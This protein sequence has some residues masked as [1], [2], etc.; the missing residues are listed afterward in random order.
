MASTLAG[1]GF[2]IKQLATWGATRFSGIYIRTAKSIVNFA[3]KTS[4]YWAQR[5]T[6]NIW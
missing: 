6:P 2:A 3:T 4:C 1:V 5:W